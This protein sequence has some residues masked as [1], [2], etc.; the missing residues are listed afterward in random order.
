M[1]KCARPKVKATPMEQE[2]RRLQMQLRRAP[3]GEKAKLELQLDELDDKMPAPLA[4]ITHQQLSLQR[5]CTNNHSH[6]T[7]SQSY[8]RKRV[9]LRTLTMNAAGAR[10]A[11][12][13]SEIICVRQQQRSLGC[14]CNGLIWGKL[15]MAAR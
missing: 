8:Q 15:D 4:S 14:G 6:L 9:L 13:A 5:L 2:K 10:S 12:A 1:S 3:D 7:S 11:P